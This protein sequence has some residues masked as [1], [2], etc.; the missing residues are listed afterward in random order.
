[1]GYMIHEIRE[2]K[3]NEASAPVVCFLF[4]RFPIEGPRPNPPSPSE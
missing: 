1:M 3:R 4:F 2:I